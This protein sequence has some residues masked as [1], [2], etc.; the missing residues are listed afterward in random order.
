MT[1]EEEQAILLNI[2][3]QLK[4]ITSDVSCLPIILEKASHLINI[5]KDHEVRIKNVENSRLPL[6]AGSAVAGGVLSYFIKL[7]F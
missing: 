1:K 4:G 6:A 2:K 5:T 7:I 3:D